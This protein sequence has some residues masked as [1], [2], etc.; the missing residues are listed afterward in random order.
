M[1]ISMYMALECV[2]LNITDIHQ[3]VLTAQILERLATL[4]D[5]TNAIR[6]LRLMEE[7]VCV[8]QGLFLPPIL[9]HANPFVC[10][11]TAQALAIATI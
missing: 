9:P 1:L 4:V 5:D 10:H 11:T 3:L 8:N 6:T 2:T 7:F